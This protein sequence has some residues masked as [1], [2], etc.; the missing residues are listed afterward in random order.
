VIGRAK[1]LKHRGT[2]D[3]EEFKGMRLKENRR[4]DFPAPETMMGLWNFAD[5]PKIETEVDRVRQRW[6]MR[7]IEELPAE[8][9][10]YEEVHWV[11]PTK[12]QNL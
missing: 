11:M 8:W 12:K 3:A 10:R 4:K 5:W 9:A 6:M 7:A 2:E 1:P